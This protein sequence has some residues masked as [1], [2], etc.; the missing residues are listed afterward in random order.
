MLCSA[1]LAVWCLMLWTAHDAVSVPEC[2][3]RLSSFCRRYPTEGIYPV[4]CGQVGD[5]LLSDAA[6]LQKTVLLVL[7]SNSELSGW[8]RRLARCPRSENVTFET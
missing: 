1:Y 7:V 2:L 4:D 6:G 8:T 5:G 3:Y